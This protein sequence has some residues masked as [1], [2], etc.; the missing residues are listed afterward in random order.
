MSNKESTGYSS[1]SSISSN[2]G[3]RYIEIYII[4]E[5]WDRMG[6]KVSILVIW[7]TALGIYKFVSD[8]HLHTISRHWQE[9]R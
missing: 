1:S 5:L 4:E 8:F 3:S 2:G 9:S 7:G 6:V